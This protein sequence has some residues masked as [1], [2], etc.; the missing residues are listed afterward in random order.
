M[1]ATTVPADTIP[2]PDRR[3]AAE[4]AGQELAALIAMTRQFTPAQW[5]ARTE[6][7]AWTAPPTWPAPWRRRSGR[8]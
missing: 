8:R 2:L 4:G 7:P 6:C 1:T 5:A 3:S